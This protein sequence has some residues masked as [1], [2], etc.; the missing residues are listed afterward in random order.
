MNLSRVNGSEVMEQRD[1][2]WRRSCSPTRRNRCNAKAGADD[3]F[4]A[5]LVL[6]ELLHVYEFV[7]GMGTIPIVHSDFDKEILVKCFH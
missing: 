2:W 6:H 1:S 4:R 7:E 5:M 3:Q